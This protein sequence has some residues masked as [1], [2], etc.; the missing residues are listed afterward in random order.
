MHRV[1]LILLGV[2]F[3]SFL[4]TALHV[5][6]KQGITFPEALRVAACTHYRVTVAYLSGRWNTHIGLMMTQCLSDKV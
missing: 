6:F 2:L 4:L 5:M 3:A 1:L